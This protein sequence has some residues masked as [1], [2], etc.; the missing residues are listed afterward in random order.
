[1]IDELKWTAVHAAIDRLLVT[2]LD[3]GYPFRLLGS[4]IRFPDGDD[5]SRILANLLS[6]ANGAVGIKTSA[7]DSAFLD[8]QHFGI[9]K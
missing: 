2:Q 5:L 4:L 7:L 8:L 6:S 1:M 9:N 3:D